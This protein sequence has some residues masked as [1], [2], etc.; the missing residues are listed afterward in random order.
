MEWI[1]LTDS[2]AA[3]GVLQSLAISQI[4]RQKKNLSFSAA[5]TQRPLNFFQGPLLRRSSSLASSGW[6]TVSTMPGSPW[7]SNP[8][9]HYLIAAAQEIAKRPPE[10]QNQPDGV[11]TFKTRNV[12]RHMEKPRPGPLRSFIPPTPGSGLNGKAPA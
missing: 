2:R 7:R 9:G 5:D 4:M 1:G 3:R 10:P 8:G 11:L 12:P 6:K